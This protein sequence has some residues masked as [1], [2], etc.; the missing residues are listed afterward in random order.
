MSSA[1]LMKTVN[2]VLPYVLL[3]IVLYFGYAIYTNTF[4]GFADSSGSHVT[5]EDLHA[6]S[7]TVVAKKDAVEAAKDEVDADDAAVDAALDKATAARKTAAASQK[8]YDAAKAN[9]LANPRDSAKATQTTNAKA[10]LAADNDVVKAADLKV[11]A[12][13]KLAA[14][15][16]NNLAAAVK[17]AE[18][19]AAVVAAKKLDTDTIYDNKL[20]E[21]LP[22]PSSDYYKKVL[23][24]AKN[25]KSVGAHNDGSLMSE[26]Y[27]QNT[28]KGKNSLEQYE[29][30]MAMASVA[31]VERSTTRGRE[32]G[33]FLKHANK[34]LNDL[35][36][37]ASGS[38]VY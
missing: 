34:I 21:H 36:T 22:E 20:L 27:L 2:S 14:A 29:W 4:E 19:A 33:Y 1:K 28:L 37:D 25:L 13:Q 8:A 17:S 32:K 35:R 6:S 30:L 3:A 10:I 5:A 38:I 15:A 24:E 23:A 12:A 9:S 7:T 26:A 16:K 11:S 18:A 31:G